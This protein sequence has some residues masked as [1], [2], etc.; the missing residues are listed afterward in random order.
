MTSGLSQLL[1]PR[2]S[3]N[4]ALLL[5]SGL[6][7]LGER[8]LR[9]L[10]TSCSLNSDAGLPAW[11]AVLYRFFVGVP[12]GDLCRMKAEGKYIVITGIKMDI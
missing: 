2:L 12:P 3:L 7:G 8:A 11:T 6:G 9:N 10:L 1:L 5:C 4:D